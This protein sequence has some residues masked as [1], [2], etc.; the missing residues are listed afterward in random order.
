MLSYEQIEK[1]KSRFFVEDARLRR[2]Y[3]N[4]VPNRKLER[5][6]LIDVCV[7]ERKIP[8]GIYYLLRWIGKDDWFDDV[9]RIFTAASH[10]ENRANAVNCATRWYHFERKAHDLLVMGLG[11]RSLNVVQEAVFG[12]AYSLDD[13][14]IHM[15]RAVGIDSKHKHNKSAKRLATSIERAIIGIK[16][17]D[18]HYILSEGTEDSSVIYWP[19]DERE[20]WLAE[21][22]LE[23]Q[24]KFLENELCDRIVEIRKQL[25]D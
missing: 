25:I 23:V 21:I 2:V 3:L 4:A 15:M 7:H 5:E 13:R 1:L 11:D 9:I 17:N 24:V 14:F 6:S 20:Y 16:R 12:C 19:W 18:H 10:F 22:D 8:H